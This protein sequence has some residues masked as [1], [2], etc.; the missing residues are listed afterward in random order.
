MGLFDAFK[1]NDEAESKELVL[2]AYEAGKAI[3]MKDV[4]DPT[5][6][7]EILGPGI[8]IEP[9]EGAVYA[10]CDGTISLL[11]DTLHAVS[12]E[13]G[14]GAE[15]LMHI[16]IDTVELKGEGFSACV[17]AGDK[18]KAGDKLI[19]FDMDAIKGKGYKM[20]TPLIV[21]NHDNFETIEPLAN[22]DVAVG[23]DVL[24]LA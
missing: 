8:A 12:M 2:K 11:A 17:A 24:K 21:C 9:S 19:E 5:F 6:A 10:P 22:G 16:G 23:D 14:N 18:V 7:Q 13:L 15:V 3:A 4:D 1:K 20:T